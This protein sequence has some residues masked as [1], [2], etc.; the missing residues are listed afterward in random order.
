MPGRLRDSRSRLSPASRYWD[1][2][3]LHL[4]PLVQLHHLSEGAGAQAGC[5]GPGSV[6]DGGVDSANCLL[7][8]TRT[9]TERTSVEAESPF[10]RFDH[11]E[12]ADG[13]W[14][15]DEP[16]ATVLTCQ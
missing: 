13:G 10:A 14:V 3:V 9:A 4:Q 8:V 11:L 12:K 15:A 2:R 6:F 1:L 7:P 5:E 16:V